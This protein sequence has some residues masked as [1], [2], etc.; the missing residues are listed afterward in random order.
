MVVIELCAGTAGVTATFRRAGLLGCIAVDKH[1][2]RNALASVIQLDL[3]LEED[4]KLVLGWLDHP[5][6]IGVFWAPPCGTASAAREIVLEGED[7]L[8]KPLRTVLEPDG[9]SSLS[10]IDAVRVSQANRLYSFCGETFDKCQELGKL[11][12]CENPR[13]SLFWCTSFWSDTRCAPSLFIQDHQACAYGSVRPKWTR[14]V[15]NFEQVRLINLTCPGN[16]RHEP[17]GT[18][19][20]GAKRVFATSLEVHYP[21]GLCRAIVNA[22]LTKI[23]SMGFT[24]GDVVPA[25]PAA[26]AMSGKQP[27]T[28]KILPMVPEFKAKLLVF[29]DAK[30]Q[31]VWPIPEPSLQHCKLLHSF[32]VGGSGGVEDKSKNAKDICKA[33]GIDGGCIPDLLPED[34]QTL[35]VFGVPWEPFEFIEKASVF[36]HP[37]AIRRAVPEVL[38]EAIEVHNKQSQVEIAKQRLKTIFFWNNRAKQLEKE[39]RLL[40]ESM[41]PVVASTVAGKRILL[42]REMLTVAEYPDVGAADELLEGAKLVGE[43]PV[44]GV[45]PSKFVPATATPVSLKKQSEFMKTK[46]FQIASS[47]GDSTVDDEVWRQ[48]L[49]EVKEGWLKGPLQVAEIDPA[50]P[51]TKRF[52]L[53]QGE[54]VRLIDDYSDSGVNSCVTSSE[55]PALHTID[56][57]AAVLCHWFSS[58][59]SNEKLTDLSVRTFDLKSAYRQIGLHRE[60]R[61]HGYVAVFCPQQK[62]SCFFQSLVLPF[63]AT[64][65]VHAFL[66]LARAVWWLGARLLSI[67]WTNFYDDF[68]VFSPPELES[69]TG[70]AVAS[71][72]KILGWIFATS[73]KKASPFSSSCRALGIVFN[74]QLSGSGVAELA[75]TGERVKE[76]CELLKSAINDGFISGANARRLHG[77]MVFADAQL[78]GRTGKRCMQVLSR[79]SQMNKSKLTDDDCFFLNLFIDMLQSGKPRVIQKFATE[80]VLIFTDACYE[81]EARVWRG[82]VGGVQIDLSIGKWEF[83][84]LEL[85]DIMLKKLGEAHKKQLIFE[86]ETLAA[87]LGFLLWSNSFVGRLGHLFIDNDGTKYCLLKGASDNGCVNKLS[88]IFAKHEMES[89]ALTWISRVA[90]HSNIADGPSRNDCNLM[91]NKG[92]IDKSTLALEILHQLIA[93][94]EVGDGLCNQST[95]N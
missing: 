18:I 38:I 82:G 84:S 31:L 56:T 12:M 90:S 60:G 17:W 55:A 78:F 50:C 4:Q 87:V 19:Q 74:L 22:F 15:A 30:Q 20:K 3:T 95:P 85:D 40:K 1:K 47:S 39:E 34:A 67:I 28:G 46:A 43:V 76:I 16:H 54:K 36:E 13:S 66:R 79:S 73:G 91:K 23:G 72:L 49:D 62:T 86:A 7:D 75:N 58:R 63:G 94:C 14:L 42:F 61:E 69:N 64:R 92:A 52:G 89:T 6:V 81:N 53:Q 9:I 68:I 57:A 11:A 35:Q 71:L 88:R 5:S 33:S 65:S 70:S 59:S 80:Q 24:K 41:D 37:L 48:T 10:G 21:L 93:Q 27:L 26:Q 45:L 44:T 8:P 77:R 51:I 2:N 32:Q 29:R 25:N 83:F